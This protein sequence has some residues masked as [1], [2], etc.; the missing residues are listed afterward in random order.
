MVKCTHKGCGKDFDEAE[1]KDNGKPTWIV[2]A[3]VKSGYWYYL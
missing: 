1:N 3:C 2:I